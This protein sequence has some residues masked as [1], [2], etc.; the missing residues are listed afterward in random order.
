I[1]RIA[2]DGDEVR[3]LADVVRQAFNRG[4]RETAD[5]FGHPVK[6]QT[7]ESIEITIEAVYASG[8]TSRVYYLE[9]ARVYRTDVARDDTCTI[10]FGTGWFIRDG[11]G[12]RKLGMAGGPLSVQW[13]RGT[14][15][16]PPR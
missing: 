14:L 6:E 9:A 16:V 4:E 13:G 8:T 10:A 5:R 1:E 11:A 3:A 2:T 15:K 7:R 12:V